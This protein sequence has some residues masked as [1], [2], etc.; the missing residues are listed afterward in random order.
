M[1]RPLLLALLLLPCASFAATESTTLEVSLT[2]QE[3]CRIDRRGQ[4]REPP[5]VNCALD[6]PY[7]V[8]ANDPKRAPSSTRRLAPAR[9]EITF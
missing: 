7:R 9:W 4:E 2:I 3:S 5:V 1:P 8:Q 6:S